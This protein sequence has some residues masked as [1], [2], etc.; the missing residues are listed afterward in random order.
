MSELLKKHQKKE[1]RHESKDFKLYE[2]TD[3]QRE[4]LMNIIT[5]NSKIENDELVA[6]LGLKSIRY[7]IRELTNIGGEIDEILDK[8]LESLLDNG[9][10]EL[11]LLMREIELLLHE[12]AEDVLCQTTRSMRYMNDFIN[13]MDVNG[14]S[15]KLKKKW[16][17]FNKK[18]K[19][20]VSWEDLINNAEKREELENKLKEFN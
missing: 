10:R 15:E 11:Q 1:I 7:V 2:P 19:L 5:E 14:D 4:E 12:I 18:Y 16:N 6:E 20:N 8:E 9:D 3:Y 17:K 13:T